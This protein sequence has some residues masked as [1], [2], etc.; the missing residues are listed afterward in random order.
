MRCSKFKFEM[1]EKKIKNFT[2]TVMTS[3]RQKKKKKLFPQ[4]SKQALRFTSTGNI[5]IFCRIMHEQELGSWQL[6]WQDLTCTYRHM[7]KEQKMEATFISI[8]RTNLILRCQSIGEL[9]LYS[10]IFGRLDLLFVISE[11]L[12]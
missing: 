8:S 10:F 5:F 7:L 6:R 4:S 3:K 11:F 12:Q 1:S 9:F 2:I